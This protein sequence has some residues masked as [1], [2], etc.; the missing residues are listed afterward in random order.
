MRDFK[1]HTKLRSNIEK[2]RK[3]LVQPT[4]DGKPGKLP[5]IEDSRRPYDEN[6]T[7]DRQVEK[8]SK[9]GDR[10]SKSIAPSSRSGGVAKEL[11]APVED[12]PT[13]ESAL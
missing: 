2:I 3:K 11:S 6:D 9:L 4:F 5:P 1:Q 10:K 7:V 8:G 13:Q 12:K